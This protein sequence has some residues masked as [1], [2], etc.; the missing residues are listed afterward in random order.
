MAPLASAACRLQGTRDRFSRADLPSVLS[1]ARPEAACPGFHPSP[2]GPRPPARR[3][4]PPAG[5]SSVGKSS[6]VNALLG[7]A[8]VRVQAFKLQADTEITTPVVRQVRA[9]CGG[10]AA[11]CRPGGGCAVLKGQ[12]CARSWCF[13]HCSALVGGWAMGAQ[14]AASSPCRRA[15]CTAKPP[16]PL[17]HS[18]TC[19]LKPPA[20]CTHLINLIQVAVGD[21][22]I[23]G[24]KIKLIDTCGLEDAEGGD[25]VNFGVSG[26][27]GTARRAAAP[28]Q[29]QPSPL[30]PAR[31][32]FQRSGGAVAQL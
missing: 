5:K 14:F 11:A 12:V 15:A 20:P 26:P 17:P 13:G 27:R 10:A 2:P 1:P 16:L 4:R 9:G 22:E 18:N 32:S 28:R 29:Q 7:E 3:P 8:A 6:L 30:S 24:F 25:T 21:A 31:L 23:D 19:R